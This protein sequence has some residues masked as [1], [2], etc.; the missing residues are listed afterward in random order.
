MQLLHN[1]IKFVN[2]FLPHT[3]HW[4]ILVASVPVSLSCGTLFV[5][6]V[7]GTQ[8]ADRCQ[9]DSSQ[10]A[11]LNISAT[12]GTAFGSVLGGFVTDIYG[13]QI[14]M[15]ISCF[16][17]SIG[18][19][20][21]YFQYTRGPQSSLI[22]LLMAMFLVGIG[23]VAG[24]FSSIKAVTISFPLYKGS[25]QSI[26]IASFAISSLLFLYIATNTFHGDVG[27][28][29]RF[30]SFACGLL[31]FIGFIFIRV[32]G[33]IDAEVEESVAEEQD[34]LLSEQLSTYETIGQYEI[35]RSKSNIEDATEHNDLKHLT[36]KQ[37]F[38]H[39]VFWYH[40]FIFAIVQGLGQMYIY[41]VGFLLKA[42]HYYYTHKPGR[43]ESE[44][45]SLNK[46]QAL[47]V[48]IIAIASFLGRLSSGPQSDYLVHKLNSQR[49]WVLVLG[50][51]LMLAG[52][53]LSSVR[54]NAIFSDLDTVNLYLLVVSALIGYAYGFSFTSYPAIISDL[55][56]IKNFS[57]IWG[58]MYTATT[59]GLTLMTKVFG[60][61]YD[62]N[63][64]HWDEHEKDFVCAKGSD[65]YNLTFRIT[66]GLTFLVIAAILGYIYEKRPKKSISL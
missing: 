30:L 63:T 13:T 53:L 19:L 12:I 56:N 26:T 6:S 46:L 20:W 25:A 40:Y 41:S 60:Y 11:N 61:V 32:D 35:E 65:C 27:R 5:Y 38:S 45:L 62:V 64:V 22:Q 23:S 55:F 18:Y 21:L 1:N 42:I 51:F 59:F 34:A 37:S 17:I 28:F 49:H 14:P 3:N 43:L 16:S 10:A 57:F 52:H 54:I 29:L 50:L 15:L 9:L 2:R 39:P 7:Y 66:S 48:S 24:Y 8:L 31:I 33:H 44:I 58:A 47:H 4:L 36:L